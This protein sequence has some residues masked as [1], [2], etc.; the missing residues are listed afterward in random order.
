MALERRLPD[1]LAPAVRP[2]RTRLTSHPVPA[3]REGGPPG[4][5]GAGAAAGTPG[6][7]TTR[8]E[9]ENHTQPSKTG[10][11]RSVTNL[12]SSLNR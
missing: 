8:R 10:T 9:N 6:S 12:V 4:A 3:I 1:L 7:T 11:T 2:A 5:V